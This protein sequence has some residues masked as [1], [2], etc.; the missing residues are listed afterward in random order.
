MI[1]KKLNKLKKDPKLFFK[2]MVKNKKKSFLPKEKVVGST[3][4][5]VVSAVYGVEKYLDDYFK[6][7]V[8]QTLDF[9]KYIFLL[10]VDDGSPDNSVDI[11]K[12]WQKRYPDNIIYVKK[13]N[14]GQASARNLGLEYV[15]TGWLA[16]IDFAAIP[17]NMNFDYKA[18]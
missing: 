4:Y 5:T 16:C 18:I 3:Q 12:K 13:E 15:K 14:A 11:I 2:D 1:K 6:S 9:K 10:M 8:N 7:L 17:A